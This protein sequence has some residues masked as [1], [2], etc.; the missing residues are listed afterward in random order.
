MEIFSAD[1]QQLDRVRPDILT[2]KTYFDRAKH[3]PR[4]LVTQNRPI[5]QKAFLMTPAEVWGERMMD[6]QDALQASRAN[7]FLRRNMVVA[8]T[9]GMSDTVEKTL[10]EA[11]LGKY[12]ELMARVVNDF[13]DFFPY[14][15]TRTNQHVMIFEKF[16]PLSMTK[17]V[18]GRL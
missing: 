10:D 3:F 2:M 13:H 7:A 14:Q 5:M 18:L 17:Y 15:I 9:S 11:F 12:E 1:V 6:L 16:D 8:R 4:I